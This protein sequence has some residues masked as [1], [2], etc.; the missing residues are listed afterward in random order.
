[1]IPSPDP[2]EIVSDRFNAIIAS[3]GIGAIADIEQ[4]V[5]DLPEIKQHWGLVRLL[6]EHM[7]Y[8]FAQY[9]YV[10]SK[11]YEVFDQLAV[12]DASRIVLEEIDPIKGLG[13]PIFRSKEPDYILTE[14]IASGG[15]GSIWK[16]LHISQ[17]TVIA[18]KTPWCLSNKIQSWDN[19]VTMLSSESHILSMLSHPNIISYIETIHDYGDVCYLAI[20][21]LEGGIL[22]QKKIPV[23]LSLCLDWGI[24]IAKALDYIYSKAIVHRD[25]SPSNI[26]FDSKGN[27]KIFDFGLSTV[28]ESVHNPGLRVGTR[29]YMPIEQLGVGFHPDN[30]SSVIA[31]GIILYELTTGDSIFSNM[32]INQIIERWTSRGLESM[33]I[34]EKVP[35]ELKLILRRCFTSRSFARYKD[36]KQ[37]IHE[38]ESVQEKC[39]SVRRTADKPHLMVVWEAGKI[40]GESIKNIYRYFV[41]CLF[42]KQQDKKTHSENSQTLI[43][44]DLANSIIDQYEVL[45]KFLETDGRKLDSCVEI[46]NLKNS[47]EE[48][49]STQKISPIVDLDIRRVI[50]DLKNR[51]DIAYEVFRMQIHIFVLSEMVHSLL[52]RPDDYGKITELTSR[53][54]FPDSLALDFRK[55]IENKQ[56]SEKLKN[57]IA[58][59]DTYAKS[60]WADS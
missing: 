16:A 42:N 35:E 17:S 10:K 28:M 52:T 36:I 30:Y 20:E 40:A 3:K 5:F 48:C 4:L 32:S 54:R 6:S 2:I 49:R 24:K 57:A 21:H 55:A 43:E 31:V 44:L 1:M 19:R 37:L 26:G 29:G 12:D 22:S 8:C 47:I 53:L 50:N 9:A 60:M 23:K 13:L 38:L 46:E 11:Q 27:I 15:F 7:S 45:G 14:N 41:Q 18:V 59:Y 56:D 25:I 33:A 58:A 34:A 39:T 51:I